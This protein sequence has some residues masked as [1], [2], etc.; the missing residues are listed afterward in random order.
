MRVMTASYD[1]AVLDRD[2][3]PGPCGGEIAGRVVRPPARVQPQTG[4][5]GGN[6]G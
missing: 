4:H 1:V 2:V 3:V 5:G 6:H